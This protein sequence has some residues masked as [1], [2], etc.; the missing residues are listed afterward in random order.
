MCQLGQDIAGRVC[1]PSARILNLNVGTKY[2]GGV[3]AALIPSQW[4]RLEALMQL[5]R[6]L[7]EAGSTLYQ[8]Y[9]VP[10]LV[11]LSQG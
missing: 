3:L 8:T 2:S 6:L 10:A 5:R 7:A 4:V 9:R 11:V 1:K